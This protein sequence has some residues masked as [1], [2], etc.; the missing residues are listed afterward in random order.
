MSSSS[1]VCCSRNPSSSTRM[2]S[3]N[4][5]VN[6]K[7]MRGSSRS[8]NVWCWS[9]NWTHPSCSTRTPCTRS[10]WLKS[11]NFIN[12]NK[13]STSRPEN[14]NKLAHHSSKL[15]NLQPNPRRHPTNLHISK[16]ISNSNARLNPS[17]WNGLEWPPRNKSRPLSLPYKIVSRIPRSSSF[18]Q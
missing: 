8:I 6:C 11:S 3:L 14:R 2:P 15:N 12:T 10:L 17:S 16:W 13:T 7:C 1:S 18:M 4:Y 9:N 5:S